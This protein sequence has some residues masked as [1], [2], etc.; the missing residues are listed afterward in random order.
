MGILGHL[1]PNAIYRHVPWKSLLA[2][3][4]LPGAIVGAALAQSAAPAEKLEEITV[5]A[6]RIQQKGVVSPTPHTI[7]SRQEIQLQAP[8][9]ISD[10]LRYLPSAGAVPGTAVGGVTSRSGG[11]YTASLRGLGA[12]RTLVLLDGHRYVA[13]A[14][15][16]TVDLN[17]FPALL[18]DHT[19]IVTGGASAA[20]G[21]DAVA[22]V[23]NFVL[24]KSIDGIEANIQEGASQYGDKRTK[25]VSIATGADFFNDRLHIK[26]GGDF[27]TDTGARDQYSRPWGR[28][29]Y[30]TIT[31]PAFAT[32]GLPNF[33]ISPNVHNATL[34]NGGVILSGPLKG[35]AFGPGGT[36]FQFQYGQVFGNQMIGGTGYGQ[37]LSEGSLLASPYNRINGLVRADFDLTDRLTIYAEEASAWTRVKGVSQQPRDASITILSGN[38]YIPASVQAAM[39]ANKLASIAVGELYDDYGPTPL[40]NDSLSFRHLFGIK[41][42]LTDGWWGA[43][44]SW[45]LSLN[46]GH[47]RYNSHIFND[48]ITSLWTQSVDAVRDSTSKI[49]CRSTLTNPSNGCRP[50]NILGTDTISQAD[51][52]SVSGTQ[53]FLQNTAETIISGSMQGDPASNWAGPIHIAFG[54]EWRKEQ[55]SA[56]SDP[57]SR[58]VQA[59]GT[60]G[61]FLL[62][63]PQ[64]FAGKVDD[65]EFF[66]ETIVPLARDM[67]FAKNLDI[68][69]AYRYINYSQSGAVDTWKLGITYQPFG[70]PLRFRATR[71]RDIRAPTLN[72][73]YA[74]ETLAGF[75]NIFNP[76][77]GV[78]Q[79]VGRHSAGNPT[80]TPEFADTITAGFTYQPSW[81]PR[82]DATFDWYNIKIKSAIQSISQ[83]TVASNCFGGATA[84]CQYIHYDPFNKS[85]IL[86][87]L[88][89][90][91]NLASNATSG[92]DIDLGFH[93]DLHD[94]SSHLAGD[95]GVHLLTTY[96]DRLVTSD[97][98]GV[99]DYVGQVSSFSSGGGQLGVPH[100]LGS[101]NFTYA[102]DRLSANVQLRY[103]GAGVFSVALRNGAGAANTVNNNNVPA[104]TYTNF[105]LQY[106]LL[107]ADTGKK[108][109]IYG[110]VTNLFNVAPPP[111]P[112]ASQGGS[113]ATSFSPA[114]YDVLGRAFA[115]GVRLKY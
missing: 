105:G 67:K 93:Q 27:N 99:H 49:V 107:G 31:N 100:W 8:V 32:N 21:S 24:R 97:L 65:Y 82:F 15:T 70:E 3:V 64:P 14:A 89:P 26:A 113:N 88:G 38:P 75:A 51:V 37:S 48:R 50:I 115:L 39:T 104:Y 54:G 79:S 19:E 86:Y 59:N 60:I 46:Y 106:D 16:G 61:G 66:V 76:A 9:T 33:I 23:V 87:I 45:D 25:L 92:V 81:L 57:I 43:G 36:P 6:S 22:G 52:A 85:N 90:A 95:A 68:N 11:T 84:Y 47:N 18:V 12:N 17:Q 4:A 111:L 1:N 10:T 5:T 98:S 2:G 55:S 114:Y 80:L 40:R 63:N 77:L 69:G 73:L 44:W 91:L 83:E 74:T 96:V 71:S 56:T 62:G 109:Q 112:A 58:Q 35:T 34:Y 28:Q 72:D 101:V 103:V 42:A 78:V 13:Q 30:Y 41:G 102:L 20:W 7:V 108:A 94:I 29:E 110:Q 53:W